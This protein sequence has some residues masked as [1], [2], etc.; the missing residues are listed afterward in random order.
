MWIELIVRM[1]EDDL[2]DE[3]IVVYFGMVY[4]VWYCLVIFLEL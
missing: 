2:K 4:I 1:I 3:I